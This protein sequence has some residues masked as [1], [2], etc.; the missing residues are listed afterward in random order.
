MAKNRMTPPPR[1]ATHAM[2]TPD[3]LAALPLNLLRQLHQAIE[4]LDDELI[5]QVVA[6]IRRAQPA[7]ADALF[8][9]VQRFDYDTISVWMQQTKESGHEQNIRR[10]SASH[11]FN[12]G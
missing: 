10:N 2:L 3:A 6:E 11:D 7:V 9:L 1:V 5:Q 12:R 4:H 8:A